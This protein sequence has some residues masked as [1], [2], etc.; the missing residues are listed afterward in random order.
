[1][2]ATA[3]QDISHNIGLRIKW[4]NRPVHSKLSHET[5]K[6]WNLSSAVDHGRRP[7]VQKM[8]DVCLACHQ[9]R[10]VDNFFT[11]VRGAAGPLRG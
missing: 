1:M 2:S 8:I 5:D 3:N 11:A 9:Q 10:F 7:V 6:K 4:N